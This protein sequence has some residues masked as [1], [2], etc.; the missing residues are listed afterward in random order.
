MEDLLAS[1]PSL[2][3]IFS[4]DQSAHDMNTLVATASDEH[5]EEELMGMFGD[6]HQARS[7]WVLFYQAGH[8]VPGLG[9]DNCIPLEGVKLVNEGCFP[10]IPVAQYQWASLE[11]IGMV[12]FGEEVWNELYGKALTAA[13][14]TP[15][16]TLTRELLGSVVSS[17]V[18]LL[19]NSLRVRTWVRFWDVR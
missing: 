5:S 17:R 11:T 10:I 15:M 14:R 18:F 2:S 8:S 12:V 1:D 16:S 9:N 19:V 13:H 6:D 7:D 4:P 3:G